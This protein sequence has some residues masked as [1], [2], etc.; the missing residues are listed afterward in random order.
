MV[1]GMKEQQW[2]KEWK[3]NDDWSNGKSTIIEGM[4]EQQWLKN[5]GEKVA[6]TEL[7]ILESKRAR[8]GVSAA[9]IL[10]SVR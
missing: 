6:N 9:N 10:S 5:G 4:E 7:K 3:F 1:E 8:T 2:L